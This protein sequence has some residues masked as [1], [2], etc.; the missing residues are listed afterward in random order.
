MH[1]MNEA[2]RLELI[3]ETVQYCRRVKGMGMPT[4][5]YTKALREPVYFLWERRGGKKKEE[6]P[7]YRSLAAVGL[8]FGDGQLVYDHAIPFKYLQSEL[9]KL[10]DVTP[11][12][13]RDVLLRYEIRVLITKSENERLNT[14]GLQSKMPAAWDGTDPLARYKAVGIE[15]VEVRPSP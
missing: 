2:R 1:E 14:S 7:Q 3:V 4:S 10:D 8:G 6:I 15:L 11:E 9:L 5:C 13:V 12:I